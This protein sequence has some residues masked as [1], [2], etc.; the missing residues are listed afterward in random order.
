MVLLDIWKRTNSGFITSTDYQETISTTNISRSNS[1]NFI[2]KLTGKYTFTSAHKKKPI[3]S[4]SD[5]VKQH[6]L[7]LK[8]DPHCAYQPGQSLNGELVLELKYD[9]P[10]VILQLNLNGSIKVKVK[11]STG[12]GLKTL[13]PVEFLNKSITLYGNPEN[14]SNS[15]S[16]NNSVGL[17]RGLHK[18]PFKLELPSKR[19]LYNEIKFERGSVGYYLKSIL[20]VADSDSILSFCKIPFHVFVALDVSPYSNKSRHKKVVLQSSSSGLSSPSS[21]NKSKLFVNSTTNSSLVTT[22]NNNASSTNLSVS[23]TS[24][25]IL[26]NNSQSISSS[27]TS[28]NS[29]ASSYMGISGD[30]Y[31]PHDKDP[32][33][34]HSDTLNSHV[35]ETIKLSV[36]IPQSGY[37]LGETIPININIQHYKNYFH[38]S[39][40]IITL[41]RICRIGSV[42]DINTETFRKDCCQTVSPLTLD[43]STNFQFNKIIPLT[44]PLDIFATFN[45]RS[46]HDGLFHFNYYIEVLV[47]LSNKMKTSSSHNNNSK[48]K[49]NSNNNSNTSNYGINTN[50][51]STGDSNNCQN[52]VID[53]SRNNSN[54]LPPIVISDDQTTFNAEDMI[55]VEALKRHR[56]VTGM[57]I[58]I[59]IGNFKKSESLSSTPTQQTQQTPTFETL[60]NYTPSNDVDR[61][62]L[63]DESIR[64][65]EDKQDLQ[66]QQLQKLESEPPDFY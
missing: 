41:V 53:S 60:P 10:N 52:A 30:G 61:Q 63:L 44:V 9:I 46:R 49:N 43:E 65:N 1:R 40:I 31:E 42:K 18:F 64:L 33:S 17:S 45:T 24:N 62:N 3:N 32:I 34:I 20:K 39:G 27:S 51:T 7:V 29:S 57:S 6:Y 37:I 66:R 50:I 35:S 4:H 48:I 21:T 38:S 58:E 2:E 28:A 47:D 5:C 11:N 14:N 12:T 22:I 55:N 25:S 19:K 26:N 15:E 59:V 36:S 56:N 13:K 8:D 23:N 54:I 16:N